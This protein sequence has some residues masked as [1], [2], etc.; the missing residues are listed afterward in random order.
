MAL[1][2]HDA[3]TVFIDSEYNVP[4][5]FKVGQ[6]IVAV[7]TFSEEVAG[8]VFNSVFDFAACH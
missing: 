4:I 3:I 7:A 6:V 8:Q 1:S 5:V 2:D